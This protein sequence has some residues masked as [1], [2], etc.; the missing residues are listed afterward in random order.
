[1]IIKLNGYNWRKLTPDYEGVSYINHDGYTGMGFVMSEDYSDKNLDKYRFVE[2]EN[3]WTELWNFIK[4]WREEGF[5]HAVYGKSFF[6]VM[7]DFFKELFMDIGI[8]ILKNGDIFFLAPAIVFMFGTFLVGKNKF[9]K[10][11]L[12]LWIFYFLSLFFY[13]MMI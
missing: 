3:D 13:K 6:E 5:F 11:I 7:K 4:V 2:T 10:W 12:P 8:F 1:M 9:T